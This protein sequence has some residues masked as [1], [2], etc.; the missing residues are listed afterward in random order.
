MVD[1]SAAE[2]IYNEQYAA[3]CLAKRGPVGVTSNVTLTG[4]TMIKSS[5]LGDYCCACC[6]P[7]SA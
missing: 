3:F 4:T 6:V 5:N 2:S 7:A 1:C